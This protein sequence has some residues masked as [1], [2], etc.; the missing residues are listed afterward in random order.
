MTA[1]FASLTVYIVVQAVVFVPLLVLA[2][3]RA[4]GAIRGAAAATTMGFAG[5]AALAFTTRR[6]FSFLGPMVRWG[7]S[8]GLI[9]ILAAAVFDFALGSYFSMAMI[10]L[11]GAA[12]LCDVSNVLL[13]V[14][15]DTYVAASLELFAS[16]ALMFWFALRIFVASQT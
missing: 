7:L 6:S 13:Q 14:Q 4:P 9:A 11:A 3:Q 5:L 10:G 8:V 16:I 15:E 12:V 1:Q 2:D